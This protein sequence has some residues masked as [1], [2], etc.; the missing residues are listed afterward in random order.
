MTVGMSVQ[1]DLDEVVAVGLGR[2]VDVTRAAPVA[3]DAPDDQA[4][5]GD[6]DRDRDREDDVVEAAV[7]AACAVAAFG[8]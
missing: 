2:Q 5:D 8:G 7:W 1:S 6:E 4:L 3:E